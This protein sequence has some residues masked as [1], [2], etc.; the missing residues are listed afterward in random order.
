MKRIILIGNKS[1]IQQNLF[2]YF[3]SNNMKVFKV[4]FDKIKQFKFFDF[5]L[6]INCSNN[7]NFFK[8]KY[9]KK[10]DR[11][12]IIANYIKKLDLTFFIL[13]TRM[14]Y[15]P[16]FRIKENSKLLPINIYGKNSL[17]SE[18]NC[19][20]IL[21]DK[22]V[23]LRLSNII[24]YEVRK[25]RQSMMSMLITGI[26]KNNV[27]LDNNYK[28]DILPIKY[29]CIMIL[30]IIQ[31]NY[32]GIINVGS[33]ISLK[34]IEIFKHIDLNKKSKV[35]LKENIKNHDDNFSYETKKLENIIRFRITKKNILEELKK[36]GKKIWKKYLYQVLQALLD[37]T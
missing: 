21:G 17:L 5:D 19:K 6:I 11:N 32:K 16:K 10:N 30:K 4:K 20:K 34:L 1:F 3:K 28:K 27:I 26:K 8:K 9:E 23:I 31:S 35:I 18:I 22:L 25:K 13:S 15:K 14:V 33:G 24:G 36:I 37:H 2:T 12:L 7:K 29:L